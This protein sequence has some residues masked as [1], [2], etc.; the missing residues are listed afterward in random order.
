MAVSSS[1]C[2]S[3]LQLVTRDGTILRCIDSYIGI[4]NV[5][6]YVRIL[7]ILEVL[8]N[9]MFYFEKMPA[10]CNDHRNPQYMLIL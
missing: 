1:V 4:H 3:F 7:Q 5:S 8:I 2:S 9:K 6:V 10:L